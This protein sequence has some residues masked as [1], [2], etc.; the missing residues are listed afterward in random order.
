MTQPS[1]DPIFNERFDKEKAKVLVELLGRGRPSLNLSNLPPAAAR[2]CRPTDASDPI[3]SAKLCPVRAGCLMLL[4]DP[5][6]SPDELAKFERAVDN[7]RNGVVHLLSPLP[8]EFRFR[9]DFRWGQRRQGGGQQVDELFDLARAFV[10][11]HRRQ[12]QGDHVAQRLGPGGRPFFERHCGS[13]I[14]FGSRQGGVSPSARTPFAS[15]VSVHIRP[16][17]VDGLGRVDFSVEIANPGGLQCRA[18]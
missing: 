4:L 16:L 14:G 5:D 11:D 12:D 8:Q 1:Y 17:H 10:L 2:A 7:L 9:I 6:A 13:S 15:Y 3:F 18:R